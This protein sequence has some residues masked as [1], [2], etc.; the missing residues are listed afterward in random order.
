VFPV[1][2]TVSPVRDADGTVIG[3]STIACDVTDL[4][5]E[6]QYARSMIESSLDSMVSISP[7][8]RITDANQ[9]TVH[10]TG[11][12]RDKLIGTPF[13]DYFTNPGKAEKVY[14]RVFTEGSA[15]DYPLT[16]RHR[17]GHETEVL[18]NASVY[19]DEGGNVLGAFAAARDV[20]KQIQAQREL[21]EQ[22]ARELDRLA[23]LEK[24][25]RLMVGRELTMIELKKEIEHLKVLVS[26]S[27]GQTDDQ[28]SGMSSADA[29]SRPSTPRP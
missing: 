20:T 14:Q 25:Q 12:P 5:H 4:R 2:L 28:H 21:A 8:G 15:V 10:L 22:Q 26:A 18:Y 17:D 11:V 7:E 16:L 9:A 29:G 23:E 27:R 3:A 19:R 1:S 24:F 13:S 6:V